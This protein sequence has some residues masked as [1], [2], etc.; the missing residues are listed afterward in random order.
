MGKERNQ[1]F[2]VKRGRWQQVSQKDWNK[3]FRRKG[4]RAEHFSIVTTRS[5]K[6]QTPKINILGKKIKR[7]RK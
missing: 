3:A 7:P 4:A 6:A 1:Y 5:S 2:R